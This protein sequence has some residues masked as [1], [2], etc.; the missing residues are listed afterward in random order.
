MSDHQTIHFLS[1]LSDATRWGVSNVGAFAEANSNTFIIGSLSQFQNTL[2]SE[3]FQNARMSASS[4]RYYGIGLQNGNYTVTLQ[5]AEIAYP[6]TPPSKWE[7]LGRRIF[8][9]YIQVSAL[10]FCLKTMGPTLTF[11]A[12]YQL[13]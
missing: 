8:D 10:Y 2:D 4:L 11:C 12:Q 7:S 6:N 9:I 1:F 13:V 5:F 3:L